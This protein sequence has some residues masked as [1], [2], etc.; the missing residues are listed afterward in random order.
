MKGANQIDIIILINKI[1]M[2][3]ENPRD[4]YLLNHKQSNMEEQYWGTKYPYLTT[5][6]GMIHDFKRAIAPFNPL[7]LP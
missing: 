5:S 4:K 3:E 2:S 7:A 6:R 1:E